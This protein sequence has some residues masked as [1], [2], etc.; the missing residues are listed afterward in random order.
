MSKNPIVTPVARA[1]RYVLA[2]A[3]AFVLAWDALAGGNVRA[4]LG[5]V[6]E[7]LDLVQRADKADDAAPV[8]IDTDGDTVV[9]HDT[10][11]GAP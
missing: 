9:A 6:A 3:L 8:A 10:D 1:A 4:A 5:Y 2:A 7:A 11:G